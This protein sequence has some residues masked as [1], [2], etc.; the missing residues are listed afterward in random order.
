MVRKQFLLAA[1]GSAVF[2]SALSLT[3]V[4]SFL[5]SRTYDLA[6]QFRPERPRID[7]VAF[8]DIDD[9]AIAHVGVFPWPRA[10]MG[11]GLLRLKEYGVRAAIFD[12]EYID[13][14]PFGLDELYFRQGLRYD[15]EQPFLTIDTY[16][17]GLFGALAE[18][19]IGVE[20]ALEYAEELS[21]A[22]TE[23]KEA[24]LARISTLVRDND[25]YLSSSS[26][27]FGHTWGTINLRP[28]PLTGEQALRR[29]YAEERF[30]YPV[31]AAA[32]V[33]GGSYVDT[34]I[35]ILQFA[36][37]VEG[38][39]FTNVQVDPDGVR[40][41]IPLA[42]KIN[43]RWYLQ[44]AFSPL[45]S[46]LGSP[47]ISVE[48]KKL[49]LA[50]ARLPDGRQKDISIP[51]DKDGFMLL[52]WPKT[53]YYESYAHLSFAVLSVLE[54]SEGS[55][56]GSLFNIYNLAVWNQLLLIPAFHDVFGLLD[57][58][59]AMYEAAS[60]ARRNAVN[61]SS[62]EE[63]ER[64]IDLMAEFRGMVSIFIEQNA[65]AALLDA[66]RTYGG[67]EQDGDISETIA[68]I[69]T[70]LE[71]IE[72]E[73]DTILQ[74]R[75]KIEDTIGG[76]ICI[77]G[78][79]DTGTTDMGANPFSGEYVNVGTHAVVLDTILSESFIVWLSPWW[80][81]VISLILVP[82]VIVLIG[83]FNPGLR[84][85]L[86]FAAAIALAGFSLALFN[87]TG[88]YFAPLVPCMALVL[89]VVLRETMA[90]IGSERE[91]SFIRK[92]FSTYLPDTVVKEIIN[93]PSRLHLGGTKKHLSVLFTDVRGFSTISEKLDPEDLVKLLNKY[94]SMMSDAVLEEMGTIDKFEG[95]AI[96]AFFGAP[97]DL[98]DHA[99]RTCRAAIAMKRLE[100]DLNEHFVSEGMT[101]SPLLTRIGINTGSMVVGNMGTTQK[102][103]YTV[104]GNAVN[105]AARLEGVNKQYGTWILASDETIRET[106]DALLTRKLDRVRVV[107]INEPVLIHEILC[108]KEEAESGALELVERFH[109]ALDLFSQRDFSAAKDAF[110]DLH[111]AYPGDGPSKVFFERCAAFIDYPPEPDWDGVRNLT[112]K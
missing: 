6:L 80:S 45:V 58:S 46:M 54:E 9:P 103:D 92:A 8:L 112:E 89:A 56:Y 60:A 39:G 66:I 97:M 104:M 57:D 100:K 37:S 88:I 99:L 64:Y 71:S 95:D 76:K 79:V 50:G 81:I 27:L 107:G 1:L 94:L 25:A 12:I 22:I 74:L 19:R 23:E 5:E 33:P 69:E 48:R 42:R 49:T 70:N 38:A 41:R 68:Y 59:I 28:D 18:G 3:G 75:Q 87:T 108:L 47:E 110:G 21:A 78:R 31:K 85:L 61:E 106:K 44:L 20:Y 82:L 24:L 4:F 83:R 84:T 17:A 65:G 13:K 52:D 11:D 109:H 10:V 35:P 91:K 40:R 55:L 32:G 72:T 26:K 16:T 36:E 86:G 34:L 73:Y 101:A 105:L 102:M 53:N 14:S 96:M 90:F 7:S 30:S 67:S 63:F 43:D 51:L 29:A 93:D 2:F 15:V 111:S 98:S 77:I 62:E